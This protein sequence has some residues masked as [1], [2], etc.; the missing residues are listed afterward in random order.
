MT[1]LPEIVCRIKRFHKSNL[2]KQLHKNE[3]EETVE[4]VQSDADEIIRCSKNVA[5]ESC[6]YSPKRNL[7]ENEMLLLLLKKGMWDFLF[8]KLVLFK[9]AAKLLFGN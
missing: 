3:K 8:D 5:P 9:Y 6:E 4:K 7:N 1:D 2:I